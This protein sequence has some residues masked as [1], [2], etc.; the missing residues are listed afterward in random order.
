MN[1][2]YQQH[3]QRDDSILNAARVL[4]R[5]VVVYGKKVGSRWESLI[6]SR[7]AA[8]SA[9]STGDQS[10]QVEYVARELVPYFKQSMAAGRPTLTLR[11]TETHFV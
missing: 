10:E 6:R 3:P 5:R 9:A 4:V 1:R 7:L 2:D 11:T 8:F